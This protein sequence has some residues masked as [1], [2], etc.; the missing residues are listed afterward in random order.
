[1]KAEGPENEINLLDVQFADFEQELKRLKQHYAEIAECVYERA[2]K[3]AAL[4][5]EEKSALKQCDTMTCSVLQH[6]GAFCRQPSTIS[7]WDHLEDELA[8]VCS[9]DE[10]SRL[11]LAHSGLQELTTT[12]IGAEKVKMEVDNQR[13]ALS[14]AS[15][16][17]SKKLP[18]NPNPNNPKPLP[19]STALPQG[20]ATIIHVMSD[21]G[22]LTMHQGGAQVVFTT[23]SLLNGGTL[24]VD[25]LSTIFRIGDVL[26]VGKTIRFGVFN[27]SSE[28][29]L[30]ATE[31]SWVM[32]TNGD[33]EV[34]VSHGVLLSRFPQSVL[35]V[36]GRQHVDASERAFSCA[37]TN[38]RSRDVAVCQ[39]ALLRFRA[40]PLDEHLYEAKQS[41]SCR[42]SHS[43]LKK[44]LCSLV[45]CHCWRCWLLEDQ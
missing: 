21:H 42:S 44:R 27:A 10:K 7:S 19:T 6:S 11:D 45:C 43:S 18:P 32:A 37:G 22:L 28:V 23:E 39:T 41:L 33:P 2:L 24:Q 26:L 38:A 12:A 25:D 15:A 31:L 17:C 4:V 1:M 3:A 13:P 36:C 8:S 29:F 5:R 35:G 20:L 40:E 30:R 9:D 16:V 14:Y 34:E